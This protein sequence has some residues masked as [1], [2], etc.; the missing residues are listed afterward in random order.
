QPRFHGVRAAAHVTGDTFGV[1]HLALQQVER[2]GGRVGPDVGLATDDDRGGNRVRDG[3]L[4]DGREGLKARHARSSGRGVGTI[5]TDLSTY[6]DD[7]VGS[8]PN[9]AKTRFP[10]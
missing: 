7:P 3:T 4:Q 9:L 10:I 1:E 8:T 6:I 2:A 5:R